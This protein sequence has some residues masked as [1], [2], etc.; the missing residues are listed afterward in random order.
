M[1]DIFSF[2]EDNSKCLRF[3]SLNQVNIRA[4]SGGP[5]AYAVD[6]MN[7]PPSPYGNTMLSFPQ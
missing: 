6:K 1:G 7:F 4:P 3:Q 5:D 2:S